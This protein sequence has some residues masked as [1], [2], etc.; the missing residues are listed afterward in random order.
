MLKININKTEQNAL[1]SEQ[2]P[3]Q[4]TSDREQDVEVRV[5]SIE[6][7]VVS[8]GQLGDTLFSLFYGVSCVD[9]CSW[10]DVRL[11]KQ[12]TGELSS[13]RVHDRNVQT[14]VADTFRQRLSVTENTRLLF[15]GRRR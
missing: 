9:S 4:K 11:N 5:A 14:R 3:M 1:V 2:K 13:R 7:D 10:T 6:T 12:L 15:Y 8:T